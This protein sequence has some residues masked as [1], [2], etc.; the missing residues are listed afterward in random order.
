MFEGGISFTNQDPTLPL[1]GTETLLTLPVS[2][3]YTII[4]YC[5]DEVFLVFVLVLKSDLL[6]QLETVND[7]GDVQEEEEEDGFYWG[8]LSSMFFICTG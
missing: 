8:R 3:A 6:E 2:T 1:C 4:V 7:G 5:D